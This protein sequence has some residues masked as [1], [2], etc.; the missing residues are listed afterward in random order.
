MPELKVA[1]SFGGKVETGGKK[2]IRDWLFSRLILEKT[3][4][5]F[6][7]LVSALDKLA[8]NRNRTSQSWT[9]VDVPSV[10][11]I[12]APH[13]YASCDFLVSLFQL[14]KRNFPRLSSI[15]AVSQWQKK[16]T[17]PASTASCSS[18]GG[19]SGKS[20]TEFNTL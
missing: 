10:N 3:P 13:S 18:P 9:A 2:Y 5:E 19:R 15:F 14:S 16:A 7:L 11:P 20:A 1:G 8:H 4:K 17:H 6:A 12:P